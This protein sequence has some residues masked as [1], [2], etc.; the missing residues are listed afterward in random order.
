MEF[1]WAYFNSYFGSKV[2]SSVEDIVRSIK[3][4]DSLNCDIMVVGRGGSIEDYGLLIVN[5]L[6]M[7][8]LKPK[9]NNLCS[10]TWNRLS[11]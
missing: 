9:H 1:S 8:F 4:A 11:H 3:Y 2:K 5:W 6:L 10:W 7:Q